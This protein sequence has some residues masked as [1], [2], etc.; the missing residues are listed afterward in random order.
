MPD[1][2]CDFDDHRREEVIDYVKHLYGPQNVSRIVTFGTLAAKNCVRSVARVLDKPL[3]LADKIAKA[4]PNTPKIKLATALAESVELQKLYKQSA[5]V[6]EI[7]DIS[8]RL[9]GLPKNTSQHACGVIISKGPVSNYV[10]QVM[11]NNTKTGLREPTSQFGMEE[12]EKMGLLKMDFLGLRTLGAI[13]EAVRLVNKRA[14]VTNPINFYT[15]PH[16]DMSLYKFVSTGDTAG[17]FQLE[18]SGMT[19]L[20]RQLYQDIDKRNNGAGREMFERL[21]AGL[22]LYR[23][24]PMDEIPNYVNYM[25]HPDRIHYDIPQISQYLGNTYS[26]ITYQ[27][28]VMFIVRELA[29]FTKGDADVVRKGMGKW[30]PH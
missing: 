1:I 10:P 7:M 16:T 29:G 13:D 21:V 14:D 8:L 2:D 9:E 18:S 15:I 20:M 24:G 19:G 28:Q 26:I 3:S 30:L 5:E 12:C 17:V 23:P 11:L 4:I 25:L 6:R 22:S 27:E